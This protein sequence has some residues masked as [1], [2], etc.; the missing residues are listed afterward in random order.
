MK[1]FAPLFLLTVV[2]YY[3][4][5]TYT[6]DISQKKV[7]KRFGDIKK[8]PYLCSS[9]PENNLFTLRKTNTY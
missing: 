2:K 3:L 5:C 4:F 8:K 1:T 7:S 6:L 9:Y